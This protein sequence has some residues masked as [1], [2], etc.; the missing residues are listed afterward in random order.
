MQ[1]SVHL[2]WENQLLFS[3][4]FVCGAKAETPSRSVAARLVIAMLIICL[5]L[6]VLMRSLWIGMKVGGGRPLIAI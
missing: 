2:K 4:S 6:I 5:G 3:A 1:A